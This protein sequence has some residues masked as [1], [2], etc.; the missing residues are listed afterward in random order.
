MTKNVTS[1]MKSTLANA[2]D[3]LEYA[4]VKCDSSCFKYWKFCVKSSLQLKFIE[5]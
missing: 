5:A 4:T 3:S 1:A 2:E